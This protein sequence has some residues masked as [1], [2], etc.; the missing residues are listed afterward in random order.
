[1]DDR[2]AP[3]KLSNSVVMENSLRMDIIEH[4]LVEHIDVG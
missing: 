2:Q 4:T 3:M 1:M